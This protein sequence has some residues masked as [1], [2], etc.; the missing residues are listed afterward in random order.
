MT[1]S[2]RTLWANTIADELAQSAVLSVDDLLAKAE[3]SI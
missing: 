1:D 3:P 2:I